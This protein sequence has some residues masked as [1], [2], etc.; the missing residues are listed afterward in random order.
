M[1]AACTEDA[2]DVFWNAAEMRGTFWSFPEASAP[3]T[4]C[5][6]LE[7][8]EVEAA[9]VRLGFRFR[10]RAQVRWS[11]FLVCIALAFD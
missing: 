3:F 9:D 2:D 6:V 11:F 1:E 7:A 10:R 8:S 5:K 4:P